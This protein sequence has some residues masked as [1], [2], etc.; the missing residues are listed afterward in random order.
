MIEDAALD[1]EA[2]VCAMALVPDAWSRNKMFAFYMRPEVRAAKAR[3]RTLRALARELGGR[4]GRVEE[5]RLDRDA[6]GAT[7]RYRVRAVRLSRVARLSN[8]ELA[9]VTELARMLGAPAPEP[10]D[11]GRALL[12]AALARLPHGVPAPGVSYA[13]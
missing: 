11:E 3:A 1:H 4:L 2:L 12:H 6:D 8:A 13:R 7:L 10:T 9:C 5:L